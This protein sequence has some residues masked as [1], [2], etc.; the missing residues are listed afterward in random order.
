MNINIGG[1]AGS[2]G[3]LF[4]KSATDSGSG[5]QARLSQASNN[6]IER[7]LR[8]DATEV[9]LSVAALET[10]RANSRSAETSLQTSSARSYLDVAGAAAETADNILADIDSLASRLQ[11]EVN[12]GKKEDIE[13]EI[14]DLMDQ[15]D[16]TAGA[17]FGGNRAFGDSVSFELGGEQVSFA[18][19]DIS[20]EALGIGT[21]EFLAERR[22]A[23]GSGG[24]FSGGKTGGKTG[25]T[26]KGGLGADDQLTM[27]AQAGDDELIAIGEQEFQ[28]GIEQQEPIGEVEETDPVNGDGESET[29]R[30]V[31]IADFQAQVRGARESVSTVRTAI[32]N[33]EQQLDAA[34]QNVGYKSAVSTTESTKA[35]SKLSQ[36]PEKLADTIASALD[37]SFIEAS[38][39][40]LDSV[41]VEALLSTE[42]GDEAAA[43]AE[44]EAAEEDNRISLLDRVEQQ[45]DE[46]RKGTTFDAV[47]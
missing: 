37:K 25:G 9:D 10:T 11:Q 1:H 5:I 29:N 39:S 6:L 38:S 43:Q 40:T 15:L 12:P 47:V 26:I 27:D 45:R 36:S 23:E 32:G 20:S 7:T 41:T 3:D 31:S 34:A 30:T 22:S 8:E 35:E 19:S 14:G 4:N 24:G 33:A 2:I 28:Q 16:E 46:E 18:F 42:Q 44:E 21:P 17:S 13:K